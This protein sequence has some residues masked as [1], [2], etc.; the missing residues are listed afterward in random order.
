MSTPVGHS[1]AGYFFYVFGGGEKKTID[2]KKLILFVSLANLPDIDYLFGLFVGRPNLYHHQFTHSLAFAF[3]IAIIFAT[4]FR[5]I[6]TKNFW[7]SFLIVFACY[8]SHILIDYF[9]LDTS[10]PFGE[11]LFWPFSKAYF[12][13]SFSIFRDIHKGDTPG[14]F[15]RNLFS[16]YNWITV[17]TEIFIFTMIGAAAQLV[18]KFTA[19]RNQ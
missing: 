14:D 11:Q 16:L 6:L 4:F 5:G 13:S 12:V 2:W 10:L 3:I 9:T 7:A 1:I 15:V 19:G 17:L 18:K 8:G